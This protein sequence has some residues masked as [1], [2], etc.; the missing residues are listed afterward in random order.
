MLYEV[1]TVVKPLTV[2]LKEDTA[3]SGII[4]G[5]KF[6]IPNFTNDGVY[7]LKLIAVDV[8]GN[9]SVLNTNTYARMVDQDVLARITS[10][11][12][13]YTKLLRNIY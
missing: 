12:V 7:A 8:A 2:Y 3:K 9:E 6:T 13:C 11:N 5:S 4:K 1:I 10:Y